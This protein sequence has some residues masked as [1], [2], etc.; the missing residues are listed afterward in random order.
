[1]FGV[2]LFVANGGA[3]RDGF[4]LVLGGFARLDPG[5][6]EQRPRPQTQ[7]ATGPRGERRCLAQLD[8]R[9]AFQT[10][11]VTFCLLNPLFSLVFCMCFV[12]AQEQVAASTYV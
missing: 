11:L 7:A 3:K 5:A 9:A 2:E 1:M 8:G 6:R 12:M 10:S 4:L